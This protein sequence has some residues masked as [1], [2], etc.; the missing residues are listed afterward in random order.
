MFAATNMIVPLLKLRI[1]VT[2]AASSLV[3]IAAASGPA[4][5]WWQT[6]GLPI[7]VLGASGAAGGFNQYYEGDIDRLMQLSLLIGGAL[8]GAALKS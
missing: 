4:L 1:G 5:A 2:I 6:A 8:L 3:G 7:A